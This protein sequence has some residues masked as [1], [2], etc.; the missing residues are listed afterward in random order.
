MWKVQSETATLYLLGSIHFLK[1]EYYPLN[2]EIEDAFSK[3]DVLVVEANINDMGQIDI[4]KFAESAFYPDNET[5]EKNVS[6][7]TFEYVQKASGR[8]GI[9]LELVNRQRPWLLA[10]TLTSFELIKSGFDPDYGLDKY[11]LSKTRGKKKILELESLDYQ[12][13]LLSSFSDKEQEL[14]LLYTL[15]DLDV[16]G[17]E[18]N[19]L[20]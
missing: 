16:L 14:F 1:K 12:I 7:E 10:L 6:R 4:L 13:N 5:L 20:T 11:F 17:R 19:R 3:A 8:L 18:V 9:P 2:K 15:K